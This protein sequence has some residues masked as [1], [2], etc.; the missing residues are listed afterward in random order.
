MYLKE[1]A[2]AE[3]LAIQL[4]HRSADLWE[5]WLLSAEEATR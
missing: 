2:K 4:E 1:R 3:W 5:A